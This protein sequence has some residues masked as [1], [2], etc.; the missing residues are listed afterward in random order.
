MENR[1]IT[2]HGLNYYGN[3]NCFERNACDGSWDRI[4]TYP[5]AMATYVRP[6]RAQLYLQLF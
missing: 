3:Y 1:L 2:V 4:R 6:A 5:A